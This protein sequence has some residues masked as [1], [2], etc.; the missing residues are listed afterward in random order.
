MTVATPGA[1]LTGGRPD[2]GDTAGEGP[3]LMSG[4]QARVRSL[5]QQRHLDT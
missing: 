1:P 5:I 2:E 4:I 3:A